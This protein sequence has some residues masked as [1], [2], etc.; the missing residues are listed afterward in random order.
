MRGMTLRETALRE[1]ALRE[2]ALRRTRPHG[3]R[4]HGTTRR[5]TALSPT[6]GAEPGRTGRTGR[7]RLRR[8]LAAIAVAGTAVGA[9]VA[10]EPATGGLSSVAVSVTTD[11]T[12]TS[13][14]ERIGFDVRWLSCTATLDDAGNSSPSPSRTGAATVDCQGETEAGQKITLK[15]KVTEERSGRCVRGDL[16]ARVDGKVVFEATVLGNCSAPPSSSPRPTPPGSDPR[17]AVT[18]TVTV[19]ETARPPGK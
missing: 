11:R 16:M 14:L 7:A 2:T 5:R 12:G 10:C 1:T 3:T 15:G 19:T 8:T 9:L 6:G 4:P 13:T 18:V 17:P